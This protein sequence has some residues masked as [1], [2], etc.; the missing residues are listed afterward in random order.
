VGLF[1]KGRLECW[2]M[3]VVREA[4]A[5]KKKRTQ[6]VGWLLECARA[7]VRLALVY[8]LAKEVYRYTVWRVDV[9]NKKIKRERPIIFTGVRV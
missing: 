3:T 9:A 5:C 4:C 2:V 8:S 1:E 7:L 6:G